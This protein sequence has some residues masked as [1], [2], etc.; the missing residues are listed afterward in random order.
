MQGFHISTHAPHAGSDADIHLFS[1][2]KKISTHA[3]HAGSDHRGISAMWTRKDFNSRSPCGERSGHLRRLQHGTF[4]STHAPH[5]GSDKRHGGLHRGNHISTHAPHA[6]SDCPFP[7]WK[8]VKIIFQLTLPMRGAIVREKQKGQAMVIST[9]APHA[10]S[11]HH[12]VVA[13]PQPGISTHAPH[14]G[15]DQRERLVRVVEVISTHAPHAGS[16]SRSPQASTRPPIS[17]HAPHAGSDCR[18]PSRSVARRNFNSRSPCG[19]R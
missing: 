5:A 14:A 16:D 2:L 7:D 1:L 6:G 8:G 17:T 9:H 11:D 10:G 19:E 15:S 4:I 18:S 13:K 3:P 12:R